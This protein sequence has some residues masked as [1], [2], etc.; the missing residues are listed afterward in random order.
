VELLVD[1]D[2]LDD[3]EVEGHTSV[4]STVDVVVALG[5][6]NDDVVNEEVVAVEAVFINVEEIEV[7]VVDEAPLGGDVSARK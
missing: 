6:E 2:E 4:A 3:V 5:V 7:D 1:E